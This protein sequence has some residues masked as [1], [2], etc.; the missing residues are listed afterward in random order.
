MGYFP[1]YFKVYG[2]LPFYFKG[3]EPVPVVVHFRD[4]VVIVM[5]TLLE[6]S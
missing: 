4:I 2:E 3:H 6:N 5:W 1:F